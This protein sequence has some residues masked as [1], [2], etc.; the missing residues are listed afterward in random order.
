[1]NIKTP[2]LHQPRVMA[3]V[4]N[5][6]LAL[7]VMASVICLV[8]DVLHNQFETIALWV[9]ILLGVAWL[10]NF[11]I[12]STYGYYAIESFKQ[13]KS[14]I[15]CNIITPLWV[16]FFMGFALEITMAGIWIAFS[17]ENNYRGLF[18]IFAV[19]L[20]LAFLSFLPL[21]V[22]LFFGFMVC[23]LGKY[24]YQCCFLC[25]PNKPNLQTK[26]QVTPQADVK[27][28]SLK[29]DIVASQE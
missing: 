19:I 23:L 5:G 27:V 7:Y 3:S 15:E 17:I 29:I 18:W 11:L 1:M 4:I 16:F 10:F 20:G 8:I 24:F 28:Q 26:K 21:G 13:N 14:G 25:C 9:K 2:F 22:V 12:W 6:S